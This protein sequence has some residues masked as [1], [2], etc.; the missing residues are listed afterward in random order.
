MGSADGK[1]PYAEKDRYLMA[2]TLSLGQIDI[3]KYWSSFSL[4]SRSPSYLAKDPR[5]SFFS[6]SLG[7]WDP[8]IPGS[9]PWEDGEAWDARQGAG[10]G[11]CCPTGRKNRHHCRTSSMSQ[12]VKCV[13]LNVIKITLK[14]DTCGHVSPFKILI[15]VV[16]VSA[17]H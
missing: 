10:V 4:R 2:G 6:L 1:F 8:V 12:P 15:Y 7:I 17:Q 16:S 5:N 13:F 11:Q 3:T 14:L 9:L